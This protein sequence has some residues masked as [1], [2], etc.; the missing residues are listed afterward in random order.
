MS[1]HGIT[2][3]EVREMLWNR[4]LTKP[5]PRAEGRVTLIG[6][7]NG[8]RILSVSLDP[9]DDGGTWRPV[10]ALPADDEERGLFDRYCR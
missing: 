10:T 2:P 6:A 1:E 8:G 4:H 5:N 7:T 9:T 3:A